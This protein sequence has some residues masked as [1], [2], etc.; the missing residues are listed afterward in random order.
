[1]APDMN[2][3]LRVLTTGERMWLWRR[4][5]GMSLEEAARHHG[6]L[7]QFHWQPAERD[8][9]GAVPIAV[10]LDARRITREDRLALARRRAK[11]SLADAAKAFGVSRPRYLR[12]ERDADASLSSWWV[13]RGFSF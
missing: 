9:D 11:L 2:K 6:V 10:D 1:M 8:E 4:A 7:R 3:D 13:M 12:L 5:R